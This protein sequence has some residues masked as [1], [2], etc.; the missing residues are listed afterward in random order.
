MVQIG[1]WFENVGAF[2][3]AICVGETIQDIISIFEFVASEIFVVVQDL[4]NQF[5]VLVV[6][7]QFL[8]FQTKNLSVELPKSAT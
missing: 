5:C 8:F 7:L 1:F 4:H 6:L 2:P 3:I